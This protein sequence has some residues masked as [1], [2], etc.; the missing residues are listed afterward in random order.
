MA[1]CKRGRTY[2]A[3]FVVNGQRFRQSLGTKDRR[4]AQSKQTAHRRGFGGAADA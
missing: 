3:D 2:H 4:E 1:I